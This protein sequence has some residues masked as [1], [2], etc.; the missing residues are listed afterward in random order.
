MNIQDIVEIFKND[1]I[2][3][4]IPLVNRKIIE[5]D[6]DGA[7]TLGKLKVSKET[8]IEVAALNVINALIN[9]EDLF[10]Y[11]QL[12]YVQKYQKHNGFTILVNTTAEFIRML[13]CNTKKNKLIDFF[14]HALY[15][16]VDEP[17]PSDIETL[18]AC[19]LFTKDEINQIKEVKK[20]RFSSTENME[21]PQICTMTDWKM[22]DSKRT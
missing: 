20:T 2:K 12:D 22:S 10:A 7:H 16:M 18:V 11:S 21:L 17:K 5:L 4:E 6:M 14:K 1:N 19:N 8:I 3:N 9:E 15:I 13:K